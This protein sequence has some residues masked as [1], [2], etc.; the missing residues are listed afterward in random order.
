MSEDRAVA[1]ELALTAVIQTARESG[2][3]VCHLAEFATE[4]LIASPNQAD[5]HLT[6]AVLEIEKTVDAINRSRPLTG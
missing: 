5:W 2:V 3:D 1:L 4:L 6:Q